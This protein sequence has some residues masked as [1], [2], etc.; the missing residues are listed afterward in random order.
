MVE[1]KFTKLKFIKWEHGLIKEW[2][3]LLDARITSRHMGNIWWANIK[4]HAIR[5]TLSSINSV[6]E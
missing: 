6:G 1:N 4:L 5:G 2:D 3:K